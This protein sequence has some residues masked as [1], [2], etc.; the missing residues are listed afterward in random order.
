M[1]K[2][3]FKNIKCSFMHCYQFCLSRSTITKNI[4]TNSEKNQNKKYS[5]SICIDT[6][7]RTHINT[8]N[9]KVKSS[10]DLNEF[11]E[12]ILSVANWQMFHRK[13]S[14]M[15]EKK[16]WWTINGRSRSYHW[17][18]KLNAH[19]LMNI[20]VSINEHRTHTNNSQS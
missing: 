4:I 5:W 2:N 17:N 19:N 16:L 13:K 9:M 11:T 20:F 6:H 1:D 7:A 18:W 10:I 8:V 15:R 14:F 12:L 3:W